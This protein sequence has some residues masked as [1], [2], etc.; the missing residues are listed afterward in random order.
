MHP[1][2]FS[3]D[4]KNVKKLKTAPK[5]DGASSIC[6]TIWEWGRVLFTSRQLCLVFVAFLDYN[7]LSSPLTLSKFYLR[8]MLRIYGIL[9]AFDLHDFRIWRIWRLGKRF[10]YL[11]RKPDLQGASLFHFLLLLEISNSDHTSQGFP[12]AKLF[13]KWGQGCCLTYL[14]YFRLHVLHRSCLRRRQLWKF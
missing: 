3:L 10:S 1:V 6:H 14:L 11:Q 13:Y 2:I 8:K 5:Q 4:L 7:V 12:Y 9:F